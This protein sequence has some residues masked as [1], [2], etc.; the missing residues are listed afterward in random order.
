MVCWI[1][2]KITN[3]L[4]VKCNFKRT[5]GKEPPKLYLQTETRPKAH[6]YNKIWLLSYIYISTYANTFMNFA[7]TI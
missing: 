3:Y 4:A 6:R 2:E 5:G 7:G 1:A